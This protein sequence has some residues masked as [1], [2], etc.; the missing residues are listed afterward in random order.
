MALWQTSE[1]LSAAVYAYCKTIRNAVFSITT[2]T[3]TI[4]AKFGK[5]TGKHWCIHSLR[6]FSFRRIKCY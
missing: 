3:G 4:S 1:Q 6:V 5:V 2:S